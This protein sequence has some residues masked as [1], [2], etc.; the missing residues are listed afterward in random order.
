VV[1]YVKEIWRGLT[2]DIHSRGSYSMVYRWLIQFAQ[3]LT[4]RK[5]VYSSTLERV[6]EHLHVLQGD[7]RKGYRR[8]GGTFSVRPEVRDLGRLLPMSPAAGQA[9]DG[10]D[11]S[12]SK[13]ASTRLNS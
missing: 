11:M 1:G 4:D 10:G 9:V 5:G 13:T 3:L 12:G 8:G 2:Y 6:S 7:A